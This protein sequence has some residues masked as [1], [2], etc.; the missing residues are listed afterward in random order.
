M[1]AYTYVHRRP[2][3]GWYVQF[4]AGDS[5]RT[6]H[7]GNWLFFIGQSSLFISHLLSSLL[8]GPSI[9]YNIDN[10]ELVDVLHYIVERD[11]YTHSLSI[12]FTH[13][14]FFSLHT[15]I[16]TCPTYTHTLSLFL[17][18]CRHTSIS[19]C[20]ILCW[21]Q[22]WV[23]GTLLLVCM[24]AWLHGCMVA[25]LLDRRTGI[26]ILQHNC[27]ISIIYQGSIRYHTA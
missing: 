11:R 14:L 3:V 6:Q 27:F 19:S 24:V 16:R 25:W 10:S 13:S 1:Y 7:L 26:S 12:L 4:Q 9:K 20:K 5:F 21:N 2:S 17:P 22:G 8:I 23:S 18:L 15:P